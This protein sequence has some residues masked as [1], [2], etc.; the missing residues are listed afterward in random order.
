M[1]TSPALLACLLAATAACAAPP[2]VPPPAFTIPSAA[3]ETI[4][5][6]EA[7]LELA[8][9]LAYAHRYDESLVE[10]ERVLAAQPDRVALKIEYGQVLGWA[11]R[12]DDAIRVLG[13]VDRAAL[14]SAAAVLL[15][16]L[17]LGRKEFAVASELYRQ[18]LAAA[19]DDG[20]TRFKLARVL[21]WQKRYDEAFAEY[22]ALLTAAPGDAQV[23]RHYAQTLG[24]AGRFDEA[25]AA[26]RQTLP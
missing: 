24:W 10:Y 22:Q 16:D 17:L 12:P 11:G 8:R 1:K 3:Q 6:L 13:A 26:W 18:V 20:A 7:R 23:R 21:A 25:I 9:V 19:P 14:P 15:A 5:D 2:A 4:P